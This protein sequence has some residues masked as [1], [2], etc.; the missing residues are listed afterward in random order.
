LVVG[1]TVA[2]ERLIQIRRNRLTGLKETRDTS[3][4]D[5]EAV[6]DETIRARRMF[7]KQGWPVIDVTRRSVEETAAAVINHLSLSRGQRPGFTP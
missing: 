2:P 7:E 3:Y 1:L 6:R 5:Q 4:V